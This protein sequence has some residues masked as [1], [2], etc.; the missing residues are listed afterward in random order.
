MR[1]PLTDD[2]SLA[3]W[4]AAMAGKK[5][6]V[7]D[8]PQAGWY[9]R[10][11]VKDGPWCSVRIWLEQPVDAETGEL[12]GDAYYCCDVDG[13]PAD[14]EHHWLFCCTQPI[15]ETEYIYMMKL[16]KYAKARAPREPLANPRKPIDLLLTPPPAFKPKRRRRL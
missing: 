14:P 4:R 12:C 8:E 2:E 10:R 3:W 11:L 6:T 15:A 13:R 16:S 9:R 1:R 7:Y 5:P